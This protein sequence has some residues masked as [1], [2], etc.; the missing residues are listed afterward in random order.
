MYNVVPYYF[1]KM[2]VDIPVVA[3]CSILMVSVLYFG[4]GLTI[5]TKQ[6]FI[7]FAANYLLGEVAASLGYFI[8]SIFEHEEAAVELAPIIV[9]PIVLF[10]GQFSNAGTI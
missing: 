4:V 2:I 10:G 3:L 8:S 5:T 7:F 1:G 6:F 9:M